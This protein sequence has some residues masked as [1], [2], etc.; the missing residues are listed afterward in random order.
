NTQVS[1]GR[2][3]AAGLH[4]MEPEWDSCPY[5]ENARR[6][7][8]RTEPHHG[9]S[10]TASSEDRETR[11]GG[12]SAGGRR[13]TKAMPS[14]LSS[15]TGGQAGAEDTRR[16][17]GV[18]VTY[19][20]R[21]EGQLFTVRE[22]KNFIGAGDISSETSHR[23]CEILIETDSMLS[24]EHALILCRHGR[25]DIIDQK[26][27]NGTFLDGDLVPIAGTTLRNY[28][29]IRTGST[30]WTFVMIAPPET[31]DSGVSAS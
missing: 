6:T 25:Y 19:T 3:C 8:A 12:G 20:W 16:I 30:A 23:R 24:S 9:A 10:P 21:P 31:S 22:G 11:T 15:G 14:G 7:K 5:C 29:E 18:L 1:S 26:S 13:E 4:P 28:A 27:S 2:L 17:L